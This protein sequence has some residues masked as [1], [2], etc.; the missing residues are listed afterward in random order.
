MPIEEKKL[1]AKKACAKHNTTVG[2]KAKQAFYEA[3]RRAKKLKATPSW[4]TKKQKDNISFYYEVARLFSQLFGVKMEVDHVIP[5][6][7]K[8]ISGLHV[9]EN[10][11]LMVKEA[12]RQKNNR[13]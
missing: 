10:L 2:R 12:N 3:H 7:G 13:F 8:I 4:L 1:R 6:K 9:P 11:Q 5:L